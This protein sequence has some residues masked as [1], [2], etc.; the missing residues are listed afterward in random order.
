[1]PTTLTHNDLTRYSRQ[2]ILPDL[3]EEGQKRLRASSALILGAGGLGSPAAFY[4]ASAGVGRL[5]LIDCEPVELSNLNRQILHWQQ[6]I[7]ER[8]VLS[9]K[10]KLTRLNPEID[11]TVQD[12][13]FTKANAAELLREIDVAI[14]CLDNMESRFALNETCFQLG[15]PFVHGGLRGLLGEVTAIVPGRT[16]CL[17]CIFP[18]RQEKSEPFPVLGATAGVV[19]SLQAVEAVKLLAGFGELLTGRMLYIDTGKMQFR[20]LQLKHNPDCPICGIKQQVK[21]EV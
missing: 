17:E 21:V 4:L 20:S 2:I 7:G 13:R 15:I 16:P 19:G 6:N 5:V 12:T 14:D 1:M 11:I 3:G 10:E 9:G 8:K 18:R